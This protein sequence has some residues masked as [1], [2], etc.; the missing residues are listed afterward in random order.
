MAWMLHHSRVKNLVRASITRMKKLYHKK[1]RM[2]RE[3]TLLF[4]F[5]LDDVKWWLNLVTGVTTNT[6][7]KKCQGLVFTNLYKT[8]NEP[9]IS[10]NLLSINIRVITAEKKLAI[11][12]YY[13]KDTGSFTITANSFGVATNT[14]GLIIYLNRNSNKTLNCTSFCR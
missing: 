3:R 13:L 12:L 14:V 9:F 7:R 4:G 11:T 1:L 10:P 8:S 6:G 5:H 2:M